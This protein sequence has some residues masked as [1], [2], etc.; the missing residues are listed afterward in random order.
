MKI[1]KRSLLSVCLILV[2][3]LGMTTAVSAAEDLSAG[4][5]K[6]S[7]LSSGRCGSGVSY[8]FDK[9][10]GVL[11]ISGSGRMKDYHKE[12]DAPWYK[13]RLHV[14]SIVV[15]S[16]VTY[17]GDY[18]FKYCQA[19]N[20]VIP[21]SV[22]SIGTKAFIYTDRL[23]S[24]Y[25]TGTKKEF[26]GIKIARGNSKFKSASVNYVANMSQALT[27][28][29]STASTSSNKITATLNGSVLT[30]HGKGS[31]KNF[32]A[33]MSGRP[34]WVKYRL[35]V[36]S[37]VISSGITSIGDYAFSDFNNL[38]TITIPFSVTRIGYRAFYKCYAL[39]NVSIP[40][41]VT[42]IGQNAFQKCTGLTTVVLSNSV[43][44]IPGY[45]FNQCSKLANV[46]LS[47]YT[48]RIGSCAFE[49]CKALKKIHYKGSASSYKDIKISTGNAR[50]KK[51]KVSFN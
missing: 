25:Y 38:V 49:G 46:T 13:E 16:G 22:S 35:K 26:K 18:S 6:N 41:S 32:I 12:G 43:A 28:V 3:V 14:K 23:G 39:K 7:Y 17:L 48:V 1:F 2:M 47:S 9:S 36:K 4:S 29:G 37:V 31:M 33:D 30:I 27:K 20:A 15:R 10:S 21:A 44:A 24:I 42:S 51:A 34:E 5:T 19:V 45:C 50:F 11:T 8:S 40:N